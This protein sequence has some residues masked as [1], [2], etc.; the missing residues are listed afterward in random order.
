MTPCGRRDQKLDS[1]ANTR[2]TQAG[3]EPAALHSGYGLDHVNKLTEI[4]VKGEFSETVVYQFIH[5]LGLPPIRL[6]KILPVEG[7]EP[8]SFGRHWKG[9]GSASVMPC[10]GGCCAVDKMADVGVRQGQAIGLHQP[11]DNARGRS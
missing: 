9:V 7:I 11:P 2:S 5:W 6:V 1:Q 3:F 10:C 4:P 8:L